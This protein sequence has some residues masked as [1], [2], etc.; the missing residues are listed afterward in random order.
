MKLDKF[1]VGRR[2]GKA[3]FELAVE[4]QEIEKIY[5]ELLDLK[6]IYKLSPDLGNILSDARLEPDEKRGIMDVLVGNFEGTIHDFL[7]VVYN[8][9]RMNDLLF[10]IDE[11]E[12][13][14]DQMNG[15]VHGTVTTAVPL[16]EEN[17]KQIE[18]KIAKMFGYQKAEL[19][20]LIDPAIIGGVVVEAEHKVVDGSIATKLE[21]ISKQLR[22]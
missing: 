21:E 12:H 8:Y 9:N 2:Y 17:K 3:L 4:K 6:K 20:A 13:R 18:V 22:K 1:T 11:Y 15:L 10:M 16:S 5:Q 7:E 14:Y 19:A